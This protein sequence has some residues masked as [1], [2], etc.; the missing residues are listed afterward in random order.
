MAGLLRK[1]E[2]F[3]N[4]GLASVQLFRHDP[5]KTTPAS[6][7]LGRL[8]GEFLQ[9]F[10]NVE[11]FSFSANADSILADAFGLF[12]VPPA[13]ESGAISGQCSFSATQALNIRT[14]ETLFNTTYTDTPDASLF[15]GTILPVV[16]TSLQNATT[17]IAS[18]AAIASTTNIKDRTITI[19]AKTATTI[20]VSATL[21]TGG[22]FVRTGLTLAGSGAN[23]DITE[24]GLRLVGG[25]GSIALTIGDQVQI[26]TRPISSSRIGGDIGTDFAGA[27]FYVI[28]QTQLTQGGIQSKLILPRVKFSGAQLNMESK[29]FDKRALTGNV[30]AVQEILNGRQVLFSNFDTSI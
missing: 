8:R 9:E 28:A 30:Y 16:G 12:T 7:Q 14:K 10:N 6:I 5:T 24:L 23:T 18:V 11:N 15:V 22:T 1:Q 4:F 29:K 26:D 3:F 25:S 13:I 19:I 2:N 21:S 17:G 20:D 27:D